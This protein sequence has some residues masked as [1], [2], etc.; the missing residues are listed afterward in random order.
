MGPPSLRTK[1]RCS[2]WASTAGSLGVPTYPLTPRWWQ[3]QLNA[4]DVII[5]AT[6]CRPRKAN[7]SRSQSCS[8]EFQINLNSPGWTT[9]TIVFPNL[10]R[11]VDT[12]P[13]DGNSPRHVMAHKVLTTEHSWNKERKLER[14]EK[15]FE[16]SVNSRTRNVNQKHGRNWRQQYLKWRPPGKFRRIRE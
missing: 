7:L 8:C 1:T 9:S 6:D 12:I 5:L 2:V 10:R 4:K 13:P 15:H 3:W 16:M 14:Q 11:V